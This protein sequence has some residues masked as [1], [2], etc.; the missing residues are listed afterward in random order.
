MMNFLRGTFR[1]LFAPYYRA[2]ALR[3]DDRAQVMVLTG[4]MVF[5]LVIFAMAT[6]NTSTSLYNRVRAQN[7]VDA[8]ADA[9][10]VWQARGLNL[11]QHI[12]D[13]HWTLNLAF[14]IAETAA[15]I[16]RIVCPFLK[17]IPYV[18]PALEAACCGATTAVIMVAEGGQF[19]VQEFSHAFQEVINY[20]APIIGM[21]KANTVAEANGADPILEA[22]GAVIDQLLALFN[23]NISLGD[24]LSDLGNLPIIG[25]ITSGIYVFPL[26]VTDVADLNTRKK[27]GDDNATEDGTP[28]IPPWW[29][30]EQAIDICKNIPCSVS[31]SC[32]GDCGWEDT[33]YYGFPGYNTWIAGVKQRNFRTSIEKIPWLN[34]RRNQENED[35]TAFE[36]RTA[37]EVS[38]E[39]KNPG[40]VAVASSQP[41]G[42]TNIKKQPLVERTIGV[43]GFKYMRGDLISVH[44]GWDTNSEPKDASTFLILH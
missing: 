1:M 7:A 35:V 16:A 24:L 32:I 23:I 19:A 30:P 13:I 34:P 29:M 8:A 37:S 2:R 28:M 42:S 26:N 22:A 6:F 11:S 3:N 20:A 39:F 9:Y 40:Y 38:G 25:D 31:F 41:F 17:A 43:S 27:E 44:Y 10:A 5:V 33:F 18:G 36:H 15:C 14:W 12:N 21:I 4:V